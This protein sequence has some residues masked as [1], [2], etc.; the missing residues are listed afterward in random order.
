[1]SLTSAGAEPQP[2]LA[3]TFESS[4]V[5]YVTN[6]APSSQVSPGPAQLQGSA[7]LVTDAPTSNTAV[8][9]PGTTGSY[10]LLSSTPATFDLATSNL[11]VECW[12]YF[13]SLS[14]QYQCI[15][16][17]GPTGSGTSQECW[18]IRLN[19]TNAVDFIINATAGRV[20]TSS[21]ILT[22]GQW[23]HIAAS[24]NSGT[25]TGYV[26]VNGGTPNSVAS[27][28]P[29]TSTG[30]ALTLG[31]YPSPS[32]GVYMTGY[33]RDLRVVQ[34]GV[35]PTTNFTPLASAPFSYASPSYVANMGTTV[36]TLLGQFV[37]Y[38]PS[39][40]FGSS[41]IFRNPSTPTQ[42][43]HT[44]YMNKFQYQVDN[45]FSVSSWVKIVSLPSSGESYAFEFNTSDGAAY[46][47]IYCGVQPSGNFFLQYYDGIDFKGQ[48]LINPVVLN[49]WYHVSLTVGSGMVNVYLDNVNK[50]SATYTQRGRTIING[51][52]GKGCDCELDD[53][54]IYNTA[55]T[56]AQVQSVYSS[57][58]APAPSRAMPLPRLAWDFN[59]TTT[60]YVSGING[61]NNGISVNKGFAYT[62]G[63]YNQSLIIRNDVTGQGAPG[64]SNANNLVYSLTGTY[65]TVSGF[66]I[67]T[68]FNCTSL[69]SSYRSIPLVLEGTN[70]SVFLIFQGGS[71][72]NCQYYDGTSYPGSPGGLVPVTGVWYHIAMVMT[73]NNLGLYVNGVYVGAAVSS[74]ANS[75]TCS[76]TLSNQYAPTWGQYDDL[77]IFDRAL[78]SAQVQAIYNQQGVPGRGLTTKSPIQPGYV[79]EPLHNSTIIGTSSPWV[80][81]SQN[82]DPTTSGI[83]GTDN[84]STDPTRT[85]LWSLA[86]FKYF[87]FLS[88]NA[89]PL[90]NIPV[91]GLRYPVLISVT[92]TYQLSLLVCTGA[93][94]SDSLFWNFDNDTPV[95]QGG[96]SVPE[97]FSTW[98]SFGNVTLTAGSHTLS[99][100]M[101]EPVG[102]GAIKLSSTIYP[103]TYYNVTPISLTGA[104]LF[105]QLS[106]AARSSAVGAF[107]LRAVNGITAR[108]VQVRRVPS[109][110]GTSA[111]QFS[112]IGNQFSRADASPTPPNTSVA[113]QVTYNGTN[114]Y[115]R[116]NSLAL[117]PAT[118]G[119]TISL[120]FKLNSTASGQY[121]LKMYASSPTQGTVQIYY[122]G[123]N[124]IL[125][126][127]SGTS[128][129]YFIIGQYAATSGV[130]YYI[131]MVFTGTTIYTYIN[132]VLWAT[133]TLTQSLVND[134]DYTLWGLGSY[135]GGG[136]TSMTVYDFRIMNTVLTASDIVAT[137]FYADRLGNLLTAPV[138]G[139]SLANWLGGATGYVTTWYNQIQPGQDVSATVAANQPT[140]DPVNKTIIFNGTNQSFSNTAT[141][142]GL[143]ADRVG[144]KTTY[145]Y[146]ARFN[147]S[148]GYRS[149]VEHNSSTFTGSNRSCLLTYGSTYGF[150]GEGND[151]FNNLAPMTLG[152]QYSAVMRVDNTDSGYTT[153][154][155]KNIRVRSNGSDYSGATGNY[156]TLYLNNFWFTIGRKAS[157]NSEFFQ[158]SMKNV[159]V[160]K[161]AISDADTAVLDV[162]QQ[163]L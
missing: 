118:T 96:F 64:V 144:T 2:S 129:T 107:S 29:K 50:R 128:G 26:F 70:W 22:S 158:G 15:V 8:Y 109:T 63:K 148:A 78:T 17:D 105:N 117:T 88:R 3:W 92:G 66:A 132:N 41:I 125:E 60:D 103:G 112:I 87:I 19:S 65:S 91:E 45:G 111:I 42:T 79:Y 89:Y 77:R 62:S 119:M 121:I 138:T 49:K 86:P 141:T 163:S 147:P 44:L 131:V 61:V 133:T 114:Q 18:I 93:G 48:V 32:S 136:Y 126:G 124:L 152:T 113:G 82:P 85:N 101:R 23:Y 51:I 73:G 54:R 39:G 12:V 21:T 84:W 139:Q 74:V 81:N 99:L 76:L 100:Q 102:I 116:I 140:I 35:V 80:V 153:N 31:A 52:L 57:Q 33:I 142:G 11:F 4:N 1:M 7:A 10:M 36:F 108:A 25:S 5:D 127:T 37:T 68:W 137:D 154:G 161:D 160:F 145:T 13:S 122:N 120:N 43:N 97:S 46:I 6:L 34:G 123:T 72:I 159:M 149:V 104:P 28:T 30:A 134:T 157:N 69:S 40:K 67:T 59:G 130:N 9:F 106:Q 162:W 135:N 53:L 56:A 20:A 155:N 98:Y 14:I 94:N 38:N 90:N 143:L 24:Y 55:L 156:A 27:V 150:N 58:G 146:V 71:G 95:N 115:T 83:T 47:S 16:A 75:S 151:T 110:A